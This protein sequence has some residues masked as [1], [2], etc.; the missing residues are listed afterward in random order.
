VSALPP[1]VPAF[2]PDFSLD[3]LDE[4]DACRVVLHGE[5]DLGSAGHAQDA[6]LAACRA[7]RRIEVDMTDVSFLDSSGLQALVA[8]RRRADEDGCECVVVAV[9]EPVRRVLELTQTL[10]WLQ[11]R[12]R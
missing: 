3:V 1:D 12:A 8:V 11:G 4:G 9:S 7:G 5:I 2:P 10:D 6:L